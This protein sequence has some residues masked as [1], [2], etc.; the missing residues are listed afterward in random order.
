M[1]WSREAL[2]IAN[3]AQAFQL[4]SRWDPSQEVRDGWRSEA[5]CRITQLIGLDS[6]CLGRVPTFDYESEYF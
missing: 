2:D 5:W 1:V 3:L 6:A 4:F